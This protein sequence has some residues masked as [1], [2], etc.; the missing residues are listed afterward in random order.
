MLSRMFL[1]VIV[2]A[3]QAAA[4]TPTHVIQA[5]S[6]CPRCRIERYRLATLNDDS[7]PGAVGV[8]ASVLVTSDQRF[9]VTRP[10]ISTPYLADQT[11]RVV[12]Q[13]GKPGDGPGEFKLPRHSLEGTDGYFVFDIGHARVTQ[14]SKTFEYVSSSPLASAAR[15]RTYPV[16]LGPRAFAINA[17]INS[18]DA[19]GQP[20]HIVSR[21]GSLLRSFGG[22]PAVQTGV[23]DPALH[24]AIASS[25][26][27][28][29]WVAHRNQY[30]IEEWDSTGRLLRVIERRASW[31]PA[32]AP[33]SLERRIRS[34]HED[35]AGRLWVHLVVRVPARSTIIEVLDPRANRVIAT[36]RIDDWAGDPAE[37]GLFIIT[38]RELEGGE[39]RIDVWG[40][41]L[42]DG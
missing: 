35:S 17:D 40:F 25:R 7:L 20:L 33:E 41:R 11:G 3:F 13:V 8:F 24:R 22:N 27:N 31:F 29:L 38:H 2:P 21:D 18:R 19:I 26:N 4:Q 6:E 23:G 42:R 12:R 32:V 34:I 5:G 37:G 9:L 28:T 36:A 1:T 15:L 16:A 39:P 30:R 10:G 14:L